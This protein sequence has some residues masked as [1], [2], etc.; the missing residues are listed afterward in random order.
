ML[1]DVE[2]QDSLL[3]PYG[4]KPSLDSVKRQVLL[5]RRALYVVSFLCLGA[6]GL[7]LVALRNILGNGVLVSDPLSRMHEGDVTS[8]YMAN[9][10]VTSEKLGHQSIQ[11]NHLSAGCVTY[12]TLDA[13]SI[14]TKHIADSSITTDQLK[15]FITSSGLRS[16]NIPQMLFGGSSSKN[17]RKDFCRF[18]AADRPICLDSQT[19]KLRMLRCKDQLCWA[20]YDEQ[21][22]P[23]GYLDILDFQLMGSEHP[24][25]P[26]ATSTVSTLPVIVYSSRQGVSI[27]Q[28]QDEMC[29][30]LGTATVILW[31]TYNTGNCFGKLGST[32]SPAY[33]SYVASDGGLSYSNGYCGPVYANSNM[34]RTGLGKKFKLSSA[35]KYVTSVGFT[36][37]NT[38]H[39][40]DSKAGV[41]VAV[42]DTG[43]E[44]GPAAFKLFEMEG[45]NRIY[46]LLTYKDTDQHGSEVLRIH[47]TYRVGGSSSN[48]NK[49]R[50]NNEEDDDTALLGN[51]KTERLTL[52]F[53]L[54]NIQILESYYSTTF[55]RFPYGMVSILDQ[56][57]IPIQVGQ[58]V[59]DGGSGTKLLFH[60]GKP[61]TGEYSSN[62]QYTNSFGVR[63]GFSSNSGIDPSLHLTTD[64]YPVVLYTSGDSEEGPLFITR[65]TNKLCQNTTHSAVCGP[66]TLFDLNLS[67]RVEVKLVIRDHQTVTKSLSTRVRQAFCIQAVL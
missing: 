38:I 47:I 44:G 29:S 19:G 12:T 1:Q 39:G 22:I 48:N 9:G 25:D 59:E 62:S 20:G 18:D 64:G 57:M 6:L 5:L 55:E 13:Y 61:R 17:F 53:D 56:N 66:K 58:L 42:W 28:C 31:D 37:G 67:R 11:A 41:V 32:E 50:N 23:L 51:G 26:S 10:S 60:Y 40:Y 3:H 27:L 46:D 65:C 35:G 63:Y 21:I 52:T 54:D 34:D 7:M 4:S 14:E 15:V 45:V 16:P 30:Q 33:F 24:A 2:S 43:R 49:N 36:D 8:V